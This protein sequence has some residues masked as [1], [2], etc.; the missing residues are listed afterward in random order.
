MITVIYDALAWWER[1]YICCDLLA[2]VE[3]KIIKI[4]NEN[5]ITNE[6]YYATNLSEL[7]NRNIFVFS[8]NEKSFSNIKKI[9]ELIQP[10]IVIHLS[11]EW[12]YN[13]EYLSLSDY[14]QLYLRQHNCISYR[15]MNNQKVIQIPLGYMTGMYQSCLDI[16]ILP[17]TQRSYVWSFVG[18][19]K[20]DRKLMISTFE[21]EFPNGFVGN[22]LVPTEMYQIYSKSIFVLNGRGNVSLDCFRLYEAIIA[23]SIPVVVGEIE[24][25]KHVFNYN[26]SFPPFLIATTWENAVVECRELLKDEEKLV[27]ILQTNID[28]FKNKINDIQNKIQNIVERC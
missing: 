11:D 20:Q 3:N 18:N 23:G 5:E 26:G 17:L 1:D 6:L 21:K 8:S 27:N 16:N 12:G 4:L 13:P 25:I 19:M 2:R 9:V 10:L 22:D 14:T 24:E 28:W 7:I 15:T